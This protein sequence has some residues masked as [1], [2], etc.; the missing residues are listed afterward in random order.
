MPYPDPLDSPNRSDALP[1]PD[2]GAFDDPLVESQDLGGE[3]GIGAMVAPPPEA[4]AEFGE[5]L[6]SDDVGMEAGTEEMPEQEPESLED[7][8]DKLE[9]MQQ[10]TN[11]LVTEIHGM[12]LFNLD[13]SGGAKF[14]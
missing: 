4:P 11:T 12:M 13:E 5:E 2:L 6:P 7:R 3:L 10:D 1:S 9:A 8:L 14:A